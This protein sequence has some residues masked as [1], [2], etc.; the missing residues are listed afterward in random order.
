MEHYWKYLLFL[1]IIGTIVSQYGVRSATLDDVVQLQT[2]LFTNY[3]VNH[4]PIT[5]HTD[6]LNVSAGVFLINILELDD[7]SGV[8][9]I[10]FVL[11][12]HWTDHRLSW[13]PSSYGGLTTHTLLPSYVWCPKIYLL[14]TADELESFTGPNFPVIVESNGNV[15][16]LPGK[17]V[18]SSCRVDITHFPT[19]T[20]TCTFIISPWG[21]SPSELYL[22]FLSSTLFLQYARPNG[23]W[24]IVSTLVKQ[25]SVYEPVI[26]ALHISLTLQRRSTYFIVSLVLPIVILITITSATFLIPISSGERTSYAI[27]M[28]LALTL[29]LSL[30]S[31]SIP[32]VS[33]PVPGISF[34]VT[35][36]LFACSGLLLLSLYTLKLDLVQSLDGF[37]AWIVSLKRFFKRF[38]CKSC[39][40]NKTSQVE[41]LKEN[42][43]ASVDDTNFGKTSDDVSV[44]S[45]DN[46]SL[47]HDNERDQITVSDVKEFFDMFLFITTTAFGIITI[48]FYFG[49]YVKA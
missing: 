47:D 34:F 11:S 13:T 42:C 16:W 22:T 26:S 4:R 19:D 40:S 35:L 48:I 8:I 46:V 39:S 23:E 21:F 12:L 27:S 33:E 10:N 7:V 28:L 44:K 43:D 31:D 6:T 32:Q 30:I 37:P 25:T 9:E 18:K 29:Y 14:T 1:I 20:Q 38:S 5:N 36:S 45:F 49:A 15:Q 2:D 3:S 41:K 17:L 24:E